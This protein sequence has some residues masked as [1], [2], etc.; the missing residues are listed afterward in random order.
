MQ[1]LAVEGLHKRFG[2][3]QALR[4]LSLD[5]DEGGLLCLLGPNGCGKTTFFRALSGETRPDAGFFILCPGKRLRRIRA[6]PHGRIK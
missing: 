4:N 2:G 5:L 6:R 1:L 3:I